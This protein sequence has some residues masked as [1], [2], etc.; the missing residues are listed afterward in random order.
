MGG[1]IFIGNMDIFARMFLSPKCIV[2]CVYIS[3][4]NPPPI[5]SISYHYYQHTDLGWCTTFHH[6]NMFVW[7]GGIW[8]LCQKNIQILLWTVFDDTTISP[9]WICAWTYSGLGLTHHPPPQKKWFE[10]LYRKYINFGNNKKFTPKT[11]SWTKLIP[12]TI[13]FTLR[14]WC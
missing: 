13:H 10:T 6:F 3:K 7:G 12:S 8:F 5:I 11:W 14:H 9:F 2:C 4:L 1:G